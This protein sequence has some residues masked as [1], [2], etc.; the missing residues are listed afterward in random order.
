M[1]ISI[2]I[3]VS[4]DDL[5]RDNLTWLAELQ[6]DVEIILV[7][8]DLPDGEQVAPWLDHCQ[9]VT[10]TP[11][12]VDDDINAGAAA[13]G[14]DVLLFL[15][16]DNRL[17][18]DVLPAITQNF[19]LLPQTV[20]GNFHLKF[21]GHSLITRML[22]RLLKRM[23]YRGCYYHGSGI[24]VRKTV[25]DALGG[26]DCRQVSPD[27]DFVQRLEQ[28]GPTLYLPQKISAPAPGWRETLVLVLTPFL[29]HFRLTRP[30]LKKIRK[31]NK[32]ESLPIDIPA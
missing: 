7:G 5:S 6:G 17:P 8:S 15:Q 21:K 2:I 22:T 32:K 23:R 29:I 3:P 25:Y 14:G 4:A 20:G 9:V 27:Y 24:F 13:A 30:L 26:F 16:A 28:Y 19:E 10:V 18:V 11:G 12:T 1:L 31:R